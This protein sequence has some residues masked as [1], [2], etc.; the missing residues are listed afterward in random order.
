VGRQRHGLR[1]DD[2]VVARERHRW[3]GDSAYVVNGITGSG[4]GRWRRT[5]GL[6]CGR[7]RWH[8]GSGEDSTVAWRLCGQLD[9]GAVAPG[10]TRR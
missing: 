9:D 1:E 5:K 7:E 8:R 4:L 6:D 2:D 10:R 3:L